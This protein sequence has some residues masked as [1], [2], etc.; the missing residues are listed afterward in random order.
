M[1]VK[2][3]ILNVYGA[4]QDELKDKFLVELA[5]C[6]SKNKEPYIVGGTLI[7]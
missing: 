5:A 3:N 4:A 1:S 6:C 7:L 2:W